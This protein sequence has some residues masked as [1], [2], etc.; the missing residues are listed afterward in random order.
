MIKLFN[1]EIEIYVDNQ[2]APPYL[3]ETDNVVVTAENRHDAADQAFCVIHNRLSLKYSNKHTV[4]EIVWSDNHTTAKVEFKK[5][6]SM[7]HSYT[8]YMIYKFKITQIINN[9]GV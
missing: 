4:K 9:D 3:R 1:V 5:V 2:L 6:E 8:G 7:I